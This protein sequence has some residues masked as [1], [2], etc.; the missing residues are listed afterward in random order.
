[1][2]D[3]GNGRTGRSDVVMSAAAAQPDAG[4]T[5]GVNANVVLAIVAVAQF[6]VVLD[7]SIVQC[8]A[9]DDQAG[10]LAR[11]VAFSRR[12]RIRLARS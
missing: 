7:A 5:A 3:I 4:R 11:F 8:C 2:S 1:M 9:A 12:M 6:M 10:H